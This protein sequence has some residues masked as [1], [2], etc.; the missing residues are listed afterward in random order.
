MMPVHGRLAGSLQWC[1]GAA[2]KPIVERT[3]GWQL[4]MVQRYRA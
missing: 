2:R 1:S 3:L 4:A